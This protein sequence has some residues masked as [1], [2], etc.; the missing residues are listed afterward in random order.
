MRKNGVNIDANENKKARR[1]CP[2]R[3]DFERFGI[4]V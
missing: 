1:I 4:S 2:A 3:P